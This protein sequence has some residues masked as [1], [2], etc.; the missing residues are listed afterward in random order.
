MRR[1]VGSY[2]AAVALTATLIGGLGISQAQEAPEKKYAQGEVASKTEQFK[3]IG[4]SDKAYKDALAAVD[5]AGALKLVDK[6]AAFKG[7]VV[8]LFQPR[9][10]TL[11]IL[12]FAKDYKT[13]MTAVLR[14]ADYA[15]FPDL[16]TLKDKEVVVSGTIST[17]QERPQ[18][19][20]T[21][22]EQI[23]VVK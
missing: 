12:N 19:A 4:K 14:K 10:G 3:T 15:A 6:P 13:A 7:T 1:S 21:K 8:Q 20:L 16:A 17:Y 23:K 11:L 5:L 2:F 22:P 9:G 18:I